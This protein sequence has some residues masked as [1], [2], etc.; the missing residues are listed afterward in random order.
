MQ[1]VLTMFPTFARR[2]MEVDKQEEEDPEHERSDDEGE[3][4][5]EGDKEDKED[6][7]SGNEESEKAPRTK[8]TSQTIRGA[9]RLPCFLEAAESAVD[10]WGRDAPPERR[11]GRDAVLPQ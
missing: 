9:Y 10:T 11:R 7:G 6:D 8:T 3:S 1:H 5:E 2:Q 4:G